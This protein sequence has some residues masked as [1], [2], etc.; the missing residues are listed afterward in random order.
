VIRSFTVFLVAASL[1]CAAELKP[2]AVQAF[3]RY[4][5]DT[6]VRLAAEKAPFLWAE[7]SAERL[8]HLKEGQILAEPRT[9]KTS[10]S[11]PGA[12]IHDWIGAIFIPGATVE[13]TLAVM[14]DYDHHKEIYPNEVMDSKL[15]AHNGD[16][17]KFY[18]LRRLDKGR[19]KAVLRTEFDA[20]YQ[21]LDDVRW[22]N[23]TRSTLIA[24]VENPGK[25]NQHELPPGKDQGYLWRL[26]GYWRME[27]RDN[28]VYLE[29]EAISLTRSIPIG[30]GWI[31]EGS[32][33]DLEQETMQATLQR[34][35][36]AV[37]RR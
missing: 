31:F 11:V 16:D 21:R 35:R 9:G 33:R 25:P 37:L 22:L 32:M 20:H 1:G 12:L 28:G 23:Q 27:Q 4:V 13:K 10:E 19:I 7:G 36:D 14:Q 6:E 30:L 8:S 26:N 5:R 34:T 24:E 3:D 2:A 17:F 15:L 18:R 29:C